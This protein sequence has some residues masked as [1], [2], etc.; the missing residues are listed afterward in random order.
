VNMDFKGCG[1]TQRLA[2]F[3]ILAVSLRCIYFPLWT[4]NTQI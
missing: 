2:F 1:K 3:G 4:T